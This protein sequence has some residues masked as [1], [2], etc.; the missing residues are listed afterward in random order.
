MEALPVLFHRYSYLRRKP[1]CE[2]F[3]ICGGCKWQNL[4][5]PQQLS[6]KQKQVIDNFIR[7]GKLDIPEV[8][9][10]IP[11]DQEFF[12]RNKLEFTFSNSRWLTREEIE[13]GADFDRRALGFHIP[14][15]F[16]KV[17]DIK[18]CWLQKDPS[19][20]I[21]D[22]IKQFALENTLLFYDLRNQ[23]GFLRNLIIRTAGNS[24]LMVILSFFSENKLLRTKTL[25]LYIG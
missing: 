9:P 13:S 24:E 7:I 19:N 16:D 1:V 2:H 11:S 10:I 25:E 20:A 15:M 21:R 4:S 18:K 22:A 17:L 3:G 5:Y 14:E 12:Y 8:S 6:Y 23:Q